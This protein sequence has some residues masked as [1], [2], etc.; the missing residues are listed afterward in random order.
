[1]MRMGGKAI[2]LNQPLRA[3]DAGRAAGETSTP[4]TLSIP[5]FPFSR[6]FISFAVACGAIR[7]GEFR[8]KAGRLSPYF[9][10]TGVFDDGARLHSL[11]QFYAKAIVASGVP[12]DMLFG[13]AYKGI[14]LAAGTAMALADLGCNVPFCFNRKEAK[15]HGEGGTIVGAPLRGRVFIVDD[16]ISAGTSVR[17]SIALIRDAGA[18]PCGVIVSIDRMER[19]TGT[20]SATQ[21]VTLNFGIPVISIASLDDLIEF[22]RTQQSL[23]H[24]LH[25]IARYREQY[26][27]TSNEGS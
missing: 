6:D 26:G 25:S 23:E 16:V 3:P 18:E 1:M 9:F 24:Y 19:G 27:V 2:I 5:M 20:L 17:E 21:E 14:P 11:T 13:A 8:T 7:F 10:N 22:V 12:F 15:D 4:S